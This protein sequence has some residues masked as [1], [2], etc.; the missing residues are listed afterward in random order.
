MFRFQHKSIVDWTPGTAVWKCW[1][2]CSGFNVLNNFIQSLIQSLLSDKDVSSSYQARL[3]V[4]IT[5]ILQPSNFTSLCAAVLQSQKHVQNCI[6]I[7]PV[8]WLLDF[9]RAYKLFYHLLNRDLNFHIT[10]RSNLHRLISA[11]IGPWV[12]S[13]PVELPFLPGWKKLCTSAV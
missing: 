10:F 8:S 1:P 9:A 12:T 4:N 6:T 7:L 11:A 5:C 3:G 2:Y 13:D